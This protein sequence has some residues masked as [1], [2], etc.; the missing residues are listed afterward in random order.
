M[1]ND[2]KPEFILPEQSSEE[3]FIADFLE[4]KGI[5]FEKEVIL[6]N[7]KDDIKAYRRVDFHLPK[8]GIYLEYFGQYNSN[9]ERRDDYDFKAKLYFKNN[10]PTVI[11]YPHELGII[12]YKFHVKILKVFKNKKFNL[13]K[14]L[15]KYR[16]NRYVGHVADDNGSLKTFV[17]SAVII[18]GII[19]LKTGLEGEFLAVIFIVCFVL[20]VFSI[21]EIL[22]DIRRFF[23]KDK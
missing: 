19:N 21:L 20:S 6:N 13:S 4:N 9:K 18:L 15:F 1:A 7:L 2:S 12:D 11:L 3:I 16:M 17:F 8:L 14:Q 5:K 22:M 23:Y 10:I